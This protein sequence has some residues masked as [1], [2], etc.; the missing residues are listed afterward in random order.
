MQS[1][2]PPKVSIIDRE[3]VEEA[4]AGMEK[5]F[6]HICPSVVTEV[7]GIFADE[8]VGDEDVAAE[9]WEL[10]GSSNGLEM[11]GDRGGESV[12]LVNRSSTVIDMPW[13]EEEFE[14]DL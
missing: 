14:E 3:R 2:V 6:M 11:V 1:I 12:S 8:D 4:V 9:E 10:E 13:E 7:V 5:T